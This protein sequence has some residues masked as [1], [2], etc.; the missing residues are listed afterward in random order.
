MSIARMPVSIEFSIAR[1]KLVSETS[2]LCICRRRRM[3]R[4]VPSSIH[5]VSTR[6]RDDHP[7]QRVADQ[8]DRGAIA[9]AAQHQAV[10]GRRDRQL[11]DDRSGPRGL[12]RHRHHACWPARGLASS[13]SVDRMAVRHFGRHEVAQQRVDRV[14]GDQRAGERAAV[15]QRHWTWNTAVPAAL[16]KAASTPA[17]AARA[18]LRRR[19]RARGGVRRRRQRRARCRRRASSA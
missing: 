7:E 13:S 10:A 16:R 1:R 14:L 2:A 15:D 17:G 18:P 4:Q 5:T 3:W 6:E 8:A 12:A 9:L 19:L 11:V